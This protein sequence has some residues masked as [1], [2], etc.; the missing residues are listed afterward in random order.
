M[1]I[2]GSSHCLKSCLLGDFNNR[3][4]ERSSLFDFWMKDLIFWFWA[5]TQKRSTIRSFQNNLRFLDLE[6]QIYFLIWTKI[7]TMIVPVFYDTRLTNTVL[8]KSYTIAIYVVSCSYFAGIQGW[9]R[10][11]LSKITIESYWKCGI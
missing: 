8:L 10:S 1:K 4:L 7:H 11:S 3:N 9:D 2:G 6:L 5:K